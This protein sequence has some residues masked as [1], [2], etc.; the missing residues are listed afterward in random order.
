LTWNE[1]KMENKNKMFRSRAI[2]R[3]EHKLVLGDGSPV[4]LCDLKTRFRLDQHNIYTHFSLEEIE[5]HNMKATVETY[6]AM[7]PKDALENKK[8]FKKL[9]RSFY[10]WIAKD[11][12][13]LLH[14]TATFL[15][16]KERPHAT[17]GLLISVWVPDM[18]DANTMELLANKCML[19]NSIWLLS[20]AK[21]ATKTRDDSVDM[22]TFLY[23]KAVIERKVKLIKSIDNL[24]KLARLMEKEEAERAK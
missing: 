24:A 15:S 13:I 18:T 4:Y 8:R 19:D 7:F 2:V 16:S 9:I 22:A 6:T 12:P 14:E 21:L 11:E 5:R 23:W 3:G 1:N 17:D 10:K 20:I